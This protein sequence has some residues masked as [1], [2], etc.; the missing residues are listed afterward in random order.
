MLPIFR[1]LGASLLA[2]AAAAPYI[3]EEDGS[4]YARTASASGAV[5]GVPASG[6]PLASFASVLTRFEFGD[7]GLEGWARASSEPVGEAAEVTN[8]AGGGFMRVRGQAARVAPLGPAGDGDE[9]QFPWV[10][11]PLLGQL[12]AT[13]ATYVVLRMRH[14]VAA[15]EGVLFFRNAT[16]AEAAARDVRHEWPPP[17]ERWES[18]FPLRADGR[19]HLYAVP[20]LPTR[21]A[22]PTATAVLA[23]MRLFPAYAG[24][25]EPG[26][27]AGGGG[28]ALPP[29]LD[30]L[31]APLRR[32]PFLDG[33]VLIDYVRIVNAPTILRVEGCSPVVDSD[34]PVVGDFSEDDAPAPTPAPLAPPSAL[35]PPPYRPT[36]R[37]GYA[38]NQYFASL[39]EAL[40]RANAST[41]RALPFASTY[42]CARGGGDRIVVTGLHFGTAI[43]R[44]TVDGQPCRDVVLLAPETALS[45]V[46][47]PGAGEGVAVAVANGDMPPLA[48]AKP[49]FS[50]ASG[51]PAPPRP[52]VTNVN[53]RAVDV[54]WVCPQD[55][56]LCMATTGYV[57]QWRMAV[58]DDVFVRD[59]SGKGNADGSPSARAGA[60]VGVDGGGFVALRPSGAEDPALHPGESASRVHVA[61]VAADNVL[62]VGVGRADLDGDGIANDL[63]LDGVYF[64]DLSSFQNL[65]DAE[66]MLL[67]TR[68]GA[69]YSYSGEAMAR[70]RGAVAPFAGPGGSF[71]DG[72]YEPG[73]SPP[74]LVAPDVA[75]GPWGGPPGGGAAVLVNQTTAS[76]LGLEQARRYQ[77]RVAA[78][79]EPT[80][81]AAAAGAAAGAAGGGGRRAHGTRT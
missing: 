42:N 32:A 74:A 30:A 37:L 23:Q 12:A 63:F 76:V 44:V 16:A 67:A 26:A 64:E 18:R 45:C 46:A 14:L 48:D 53:A 22:V 7:G 15:R 27:A 56:W 61:A 31:G 69:S 70:A 8:D 68:S 59:T 17:P 79:S 51:P 28:D 34:A 49:F 19:F 77:F 73:P 5:P 66:P 52:V 55:R 80:G 71:V 47:P 39:R 9:A 81:L 62:G 65:T 33:T 10:D 1:L 41:D 11:S 78:L 50:Y 21:F 43:P 4:Y 3:G 35:L 13:D 2:L 36:V 60:V 75:W 54:S 25:Q 20:V 6:A 58:L 72:V 57:L 29:E 24:P 38:L 40:Q